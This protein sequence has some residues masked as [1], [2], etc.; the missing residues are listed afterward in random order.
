[1][2]SGQ[3]EAARIEGLLGHLLD[4][5]PDDGVEELRTKY[6]ARLQQLRQETN[7]ERQL[8]PTVQLLRAQRLTRKRGRQRETSST[9]LTALETQLALVHSQ[10]DE[11]R[12]A[13]EK[14]DDALSEAR[15]EEEGVRQNLLSPTTPKCSTRDL[16]SD[17]QDLMAQLDALPTAVQDGKLE[18]AQA[19]L[20]AQLGRIASAIQ[21]F[22]AP[23][24][25]AHGDPYCVSV[26]SEAPSEGEN[27]IVT[28]PRPQGTDPDTS[29]RRGT[30]PARGARSRSRSNGS[31]SSDDK[32][33]QMRR[34]AQQ[35]GQKQI[36]GWF[37]S[38][39]KDKSRG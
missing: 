33:V 8:D 11:A 24:S 37:A 23:A 15:L 3:D 28:Q 1:M 18:S 20:R 13:L 22:A 30:S 10:V 38:T 35:S 16:S 32:S 39:T 14:A 9:K 7:A 4:F 17:V 25:Q 29:G 21:T 34:S 2:S 26:Q 5:P 31:G 36:R 12:A 27:D 6:R 19:D